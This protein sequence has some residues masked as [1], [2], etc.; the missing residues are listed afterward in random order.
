MAAGIDVSNPENQFMVKINATLT[1]GKKKIN[2]S[3][4]YNQITGH[5]ISKPTVVTTSDGEKGK[6]FLHILKPNGFNLWK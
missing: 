3:F 6:L 4:T 2:T 5:T 1:Y